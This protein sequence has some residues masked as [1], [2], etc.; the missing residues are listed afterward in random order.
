M[1]RMYC[2]ANWFNL[3]DAAC[4]DALYDGAAS[5]DFCQAGLGLEGVPGATTLSTFRL[6][7]EKHKLGI[8][9][10]A[11]V[12]ELLLASGLKLCGGTVVDAT[13]KSLHPAPPKIQTKLVIPKCT[14]PV[15]P[16]NGTLA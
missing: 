4:E 8:A 2:V 3:A 14:K 13:I 16:G 1:L 9:I 6:L 7:L 15:K 10:F 11:K 5:K 12:G